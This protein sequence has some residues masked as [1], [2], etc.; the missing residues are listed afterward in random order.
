MRILAI[1]TSCDETSVAI[2][3]A[4]GG[5]ES[6]NFRVLANIVSSQADLHAEYG[7]IFPTLAKREHLKNLPLVLDEALKTAKKTLRLNGLTSDVNHL[8]FSDLNI[9]II[10]VTVGPGL[11]PAL[12][13]GI[14]FAK[15][16]AKKWDKPLVAVNHMEGH[17][18][19]VLLGQNTGSTKSQTTKNKVQFPAIALLVSGGHTEIVLIKKWLD[20]KIIGETRDDASGEAFDKAARMLGL[21]YPGGPLIS[22]EAEKAR[23]SKRPPS[24]RLRQ[25]SEIRKNLKNSEIVSDFEF[26]ASDLTLPRPM[27]HSKDYDFSFSGLKTALLYLIRDI[28][29]VRESENISDLVPELAHEFQNA[30]VET[31]VAKTIRA[32]KEYNAK[33]LIL[34]GGVANNKLLQTSLAESVLKSSPHT[35]LHIPHLSYTTDNGAMIG[36]AGYFRAF[37]NEH[38]KN[39]NS[40]RAVGNLRLESK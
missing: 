8:E 34:A 15:D 6:P 29:K 40:L 32:V 19:S 5:F 37:R 2:I 36:S 33:S 9:D 14:E 21:G 10:A 23:N 22:M 11:E 24:P 1:E 35:T 28:R 25:A 16:L 12:W 7:G 17:I 27:I 4:E 13:T 39:M 20:Y 3:D 31:L 38:V 30:I 18:A 26:S